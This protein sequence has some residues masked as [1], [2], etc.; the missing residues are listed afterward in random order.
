MKKENQK[1]KEKS[2]N[3]VFRD[4]AAELRQKMVEKLVTEGKVKTFR[5]GCRVLKAKEIKDTAKRIENHFVSEDE[6]ELQR[7]MKEQKNY[8]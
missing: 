6:K 1:Y 3:D 2:L 8:E 5:E 4:Q 7:L